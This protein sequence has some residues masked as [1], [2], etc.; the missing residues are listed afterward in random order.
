MAN[1]S[2]KLI[3]QESYFIAPEVKHFVFQRE[4][5]TALH[6]IPGQFITLMLTRADKLVRR[7]YSLAAAPNLEGNIEFAASFV[8]K[9]FA[10]E[11][12]FGLKRGDELLA[13]GP[14]GRLILPNQAEKRYI[15]VATGT[16][17]TPYRTM[18]P[19]LAM[20]MQ[21][22]QSEVV[23]IQGVRKLEDLLYADEFHQFAKA[24][25]QFSYRPCLSRVVTLPMHHY[26][27]YVHQQFDLINLSPTADLFYLCGNP[28]MIDES[29]EKLTALGFDS[30]RIRR[31]KYISST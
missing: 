12:L 22:D 7:S 27:G 3:M 2:F 19:E 16:G 17:V 28:N 10:S 26:N 11:Y 5:K 29:F 20:R 15:L 8:A 21:R 1:V 18:L 25:A 31:E 30:A 13:T 23:L 6:F 4:D 9:G 24:H 14:F